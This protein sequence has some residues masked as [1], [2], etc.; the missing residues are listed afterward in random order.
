MKEFKGKNAAVLG[1]GKSGI[2]AARALKKIGANVFISESGNPSPSLPADLKSVP[3]EFGG[4]TE[5]ILAQDILVVSPG[6]HLDIPIIEKARQKGLIILNELELGWRLGHF[7]SVA[8]ITGTNGKTTT[9]AL[10]AH[11]CKTAGFETL[12]AGNIGEP[13][14]DYFDASEKYEKIILEVSSYQLESCSLFRPDVACVLNLTPDH[15]E[16][17]GTMEEYAGVKK[18]IFMNQGA[19]DYSVLNWDDPACRKMSDGLKSKTIFFSVNS[20]L[21]AGVCMNAKTLKI[22]Y[23]LGVKGTLPFPKYLP[24]RHNIENSC[25][26][27]AAA[28]ALGVPP[29]AIAESLETFKGVPHRLER[30]RTVKGV[31][32]INDSKG[33]NVDSTLKALEAVPGPLWLILG[34]QDKG[35]PYAPLK[36]LIRAKAKGILLIG[37]A[38][39]KIQKEL[40][41]EAEMILCGTLEKAVSEAHARA[42]T[43]DSVLLSP[44]CASFDQFK[45]FEDRGDQF[46]DAVKKLKA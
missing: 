46:R 33:T 19:E 2:S 37:E 31:D 22:E 24:G 34:G 14:C 9:T 7:K 10:L 30:V 17:H 45:N 20:P 23:Q 6:I 1:L 8:A 36:N 5:K 12:A 44:A 29:K 4:H 28:I 13:L 11:M 18:R 32:Y 3:A 15:L 40:A 25:A 26:A 39:E 21:A 16:R 38:A 42:R 41:G 43:G 35:A 27:S